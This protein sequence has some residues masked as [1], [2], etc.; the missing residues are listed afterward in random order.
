MSFFSI[1]P[2]NLKISPA[3]STWRHPSQETADWQHFMRSRSLEPLHGMAVWSL[4]PTVI[5]LHK[6]V[7]GLG[8]TVLDYQDPVHPTESV[9]VVKSLVPGGVAHVDGR[10]MPGDRLQ[11]VND[12]CLANATLDEAVNALKN[13][14]EGDVILAVCKPLPIDDQVSD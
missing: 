12:V 2:Q 6:G 1:F 7:K 11:Y 10:L 8:F 13:A 14:E 9:I 4:H 3:I 5:R